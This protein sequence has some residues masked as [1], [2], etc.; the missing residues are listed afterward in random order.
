MTKRLER[1][2]LEFLRTLRFP[3]EKTRY[4]GLRNPYHA[5]KNVN[6]PVNQRVPW[7][8]DPRRAKEKPLSDRAMRRPSTL[9]GL[10]GDL[11][12][13]AAQYTERM[14]RH[15]S[16]L[17]WGLGETGASLQ[18]PAGSFLLLPW[19]VSPS[20]SLSYSCCPPCYLTFCLLLRLAFIHLFSLYPSLLFSSLSTAWIFPTL[21][22][23]KWLSTFDSVSL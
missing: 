23:F 6:D 12:S 13:T 2:L 4:S 22:N 3:L 16:R 21:S 19:S 7:Q 10:P 17:K 14:R 20:L 8:I 5:K 11:P 18:L 1:F 15:G 9:A